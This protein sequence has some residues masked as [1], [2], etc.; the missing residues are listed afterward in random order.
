MTGLVPPAGLD[1]HDL[2]VVVTDLVGELGVDVHHLVGELADALSDQDVVQVTNFVG[3]MYGL[4]E[5]I[6]WM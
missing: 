2:R 3:P 1:V 5:V 4:S 6:S